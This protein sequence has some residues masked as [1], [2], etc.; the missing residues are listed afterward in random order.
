MALE[1]K[2]E[3][4]PFPALRMAKGQRSFNGLQVIGGKIL[5]ECNR[6]LRWP[7]CMVTYKAM[8]KDATIAPALA[9][10]EMNI[11]KV[12]WT[13]KIPEGYDEQLSEKADFL[14]SVMNDMDHSFEDFINS[15]STF[16]RFG[17]GLNEKVYRRRLKSKGSKY[18]DNL[19][20]IASLPIISQ[21]TIA[22]WEWDADGRK[23][24]GIKQWVNKPHGQDGIV[25]S[26]EASPVAIPRHKFLMFRADPLK[27]NP[28]GLSPLNGVYMAWRFKTE[29][30]RFESMGVSQDLRGLKVLKIPARYMSEEASED[31][32]ATY[33]MF[34]KAMALLHKGEQSAIII[35]SDVSEEKVPLFDFKLES[36]MGQSTHNIHEIIGRY[37]KEI[38]TGLLCQQLILGQDGSGS[39]ALSESLEGATDT[40]IDAR[41]R[42]IRNQLNHDLVPQLFALNGWDTDILPYFDFEEVKKSSMDDFSKSIQRIASVGGLVLNAETINTIHEKLGLPVPFDQTDIDIEE[43]REM[44]TP[45]ISNA[46]EGMQTGSGNGTSSSAAGRDNSASNLEN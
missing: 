12:K 18:D 45:D 5:E 40:V 23:L 9:L 19:Y 10:M 6:D 14:R 25:S 30:E 22:S 26:I 16:N 38:I 27:N 31:E 43:V 4:G 3:E 17:F 34:T 44:T 24:T 2:L 15:V 21:D 35:P 13:V 42:E 37:R 29:L 39:F 41:L 32:K 46:G 33:E 11:S 28:E 36:V 7:Q 20:G 8:F 1:E